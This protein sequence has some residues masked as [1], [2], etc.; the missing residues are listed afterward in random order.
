MIL[1]NYSVLHITSTQSIRFTRVDKI[2]RLRYSYWCMKV[3]FL[4]GVDC[5][6]YDHKMRDT[7]PKYYQKWAQINVEAIERDGRMINIAL[8]D[9][10]TIENVPVSAIQITS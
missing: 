10:D 4:R 7:Y 6:Y 1:H 3:T 8:F 5:D 2:R 9:G